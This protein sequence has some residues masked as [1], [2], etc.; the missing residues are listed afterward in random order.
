MGLTRGKSRKKVGLALGSGASRGL[1]HIGV[2]EVLEKEG[3]P[4]DMIAGTSM[5]AL[6]GAIYAHG[7]DIEQMKNLAITLGAKRLGLVDLTLPKTGLLR[8]RKIEDTLKLVIGEA[9]FSDLKIPFACVATDIDCGEEVV[10]K[11][12][13]VREAARASSSIPA[14]LAVVKL[15][16]KYLVDGTLV[17]PV[18]VSV[19]RAMGADIVIAV[20]VIP[21]REITGKTAPNIF[22][23]IMQTIHISSYGIIKANLAGADIVIE[24]DI[25]NIGYADFSRV[26]E[27]ILQGE[28]AAREAIPEIKNAM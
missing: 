11:E 1:A 9:K 7:Q 28:L 10:F 6:V 12:G 25:S 24:P 4:I 17:N 27:C 22:A 16:G 21:R 23:I 14:I 26:Q 5:G 19:V 20:N 3:I 8:G 13:L 2:I 18:P 15:G